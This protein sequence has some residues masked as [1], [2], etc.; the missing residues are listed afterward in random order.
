MSRLTKLSFVPLV[1]GLGVLLVGLA[2]DVLYAGIPF[3]DPPPA[4]A[5]RYQANA[6]IASGIEAWGANLALLGCGIV[7]VVQVVTRMRRRATARRLRAG[8]G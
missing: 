4:L 7:V 5:L 8:P 2:F 3:Q 1:V 6:R